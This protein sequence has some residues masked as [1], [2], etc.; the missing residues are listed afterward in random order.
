MQMRR[1]KDAIAELR[2]AIRLDPDLFLAYFS[3]N[4]VYLYEVA[5]LDSAIEVAQRQLAR[6]PNSAFAYAQLG[7]AH[8]GKRDL[9][10]AEDALRKAVELDPDPR[11]VLNHYG[12]GHTLRLQGRFDEARRVFLHVLEIAPEEISAHYEAGAVSQL[13]GDNAVARKHFETVIAESNRYLQGSPQDVERRLELASAWARLG[14]LARAGAM[15]RRLESLT[16]DLPVERAGVQVLLGK[17]DEA[18]N[19]LQRAVLNGY[20]NVVWLRINTDLH[21]LQGDPRLEDII[22]QMR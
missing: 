5:D 11:S 14:D 15:A 1:F 7:A 20:R 21:A 3:L 2:E 6:S 17:T 16:P 13:M 10:Q 12:L 4:S 18:L 22:A 9:R 19:I 8:S